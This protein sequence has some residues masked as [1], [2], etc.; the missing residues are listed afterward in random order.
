[1]YKAFRFCHVLYSPGLHGWHA[2]EEGTE[3]D[4]HVEHDPF[5][6]LTLSGEHGAG[7]QSD[8]VDLGGDDGVLKGH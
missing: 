6:S 2:S 4:G 5:K 8:R 7:A 3:P 1:M